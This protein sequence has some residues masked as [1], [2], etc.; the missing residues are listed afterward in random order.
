MITV[1]ICVHSM[2]ELH[3][4]FLSDALFSLRSQTYK[5]FKT[6][7]VL[8]ECWDKTKKVVEEIKF[9]KDTLLVIERDKKEGLAYAKNYGLSFVDT[10]YVAFLDAD[11]LYE[12]TKLEKQA[13]FIKDNDVDFLGTQHSDITTT[14]RITKYTSPFYHTTY[15]THDDIV[16]ALPTQNILTHGSMLIKTK[17]LKELGYYNHVKG[18]EDWDLWKRAAK[19]GYKFHQLPERLYIWCEG[20]SVAR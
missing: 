7:I 18:V 5:D 8:D 11:D 12:P 6:I 1:L 2:N 17:A 14:D 16:N 3:D 20:S 15:T 19:A 9:D 4:K 13:E 10:E